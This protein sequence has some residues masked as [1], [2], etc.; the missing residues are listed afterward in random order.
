MDTLDTLEPH[1]GG[2][3]QNDPG[4][5]CLPFYAI[6]FIATIGVSLAVCAIT[7]SILA[8]VIYP[9]IEHSKV[10]IMHLG[11]DIRKGAEAQINR[12]RGGGRRHQDRAE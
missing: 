3:G 4:D 5:T 11:G 8:I 10:Q 6:L 7:F 2:Y 1:L 12:L 9:K